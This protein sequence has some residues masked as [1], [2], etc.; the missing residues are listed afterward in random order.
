V[1]YPFCSA[2]SVKWLF[3]VH[4]ETG[5]AATCLSAIVD[6]PSG[7][8]RIVRSGNSDLIEGIIEEEDASAQVLKIREI[9]TGTFCFNTQQLFSA[10]DE[11]DN[12]NTQGEYYLTDT[13]K[14]MYNNGLRVSVVT[15]ENPDEVLGVNSTEQ[16]ES[17]AKKFA[18]IVKQG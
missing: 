3:R 13:V 12:Q 14:V 11:V 15:A 16:L 8:G 10:L 1:T 2:T 9:N 17:L 7:Y 6:N 5:A 4:E 18:Y